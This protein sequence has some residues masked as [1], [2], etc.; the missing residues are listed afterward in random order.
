MEK[1]RMTYRVLLMCSGVWCALFVAAPLLSSGESS[2]AP[3]LYKAFS[4]VCHQFP[5]R[6]FSLAGHPF[7]VCIRCTLIYV[8]FVASLLFYPY[9]S[10]RKNLLPDVRILLLAFVPMAIDGMLQLLGLSQSTTLTRI[11]TGTLAGIVLPFLVVPPLQE[12]VDRLCAQF[13][14]PANAGKTQ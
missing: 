4:H 8:G 12:A 1:A 14:D 11:V 2:L 13:G 9:L 3:P 7:A 6:S 10:R 5:D